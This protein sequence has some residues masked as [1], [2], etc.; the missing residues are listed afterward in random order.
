MSLKIRFSAAAVL[1]VLMLAAT[2]LVSNAMAQGS[3]KPAA[4]ATTSS[5]TPTKPKA[6]AAKPAAK[7]TDKAEEIIW[8]DLLPPGEEAR[9][10]KLYDDYFREMEA[11]L[12]GSQTQLTAPT[13]MGKPPMDLGLMDLG[14][15]SEGSALDSMPQIGTFNT[16]ADL[17]NKKIRI[18]AY[19]VPLDFSAKGSYKEF[20][21]APYFGACIHTPPPP[22]N[23]IIYVK[24]NP[25]AKI[26]DIWGAVWAEGILTTTRHENGVGSAAYTLK[27]T[28]IEHYE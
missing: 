12:R 24:A 25:P 27:L 11:R 14:S 8:D 3:A 13:R 9:I 17:N 5:A 2:M 10:E 6:P 4:P 20:L 21:L 1:T 16:V 7:P 28:K 23:Q 18:P 26:A 22:P 19:I 15:I